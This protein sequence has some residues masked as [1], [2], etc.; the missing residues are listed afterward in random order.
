MIDALQQGID[1]VAGQQHG[2]DDLLHLLHGEGNTAVQGFQRVGP[3]LERV[4]EQEQAA[5]LLDNGPRLLGHGLRL[6]VDVTHQA[7]RAAVDVVQHVL[8]AGPDVL[9]R[10]HRGSGVGFGRGAGSGFFVLGL[11]VLFGVGFAVV[12]LGRF[13]GQGT[14]RA[15]EGGQ[16]PAGVSG[17]SR[18]EA[19]DGQQHENGQ[20]TEQAAIHGPPQGKAPAGKGQRHHGI[21]KPAIAQDVLVEKSICPVKAAFFPFREQADGPALQALPCPA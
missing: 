9:Q 1:A 19:E 16:L 10:V 12:F 11:V 8:L 3:V 20:G 4:D 15:D 18:H 7:A 6:L 13:I 2:I 21:E 14:S 5:G 17:E